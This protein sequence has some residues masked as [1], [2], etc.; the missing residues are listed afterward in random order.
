MVR[1]YDKREM[2]NK[3]LDEICPQIRKMLEKAQPGTRYCNV[4][5]DVGQKFQVNIADQGYV[6]SLE[7]HICP[8]RQWN[9][10]GMPCSHA[11]ACIHFMKHDSVA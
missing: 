11:L 7:E 3:C 8:Y 2:M 10:S 4:R 9:L 6:V 5:L 1:M